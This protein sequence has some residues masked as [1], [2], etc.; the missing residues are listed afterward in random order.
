MVV[1]KS[2]AS[3]IPSSKSTE[4][5]YKVHDKSVQNSNK[6]NVKRE[7]VVKELDVKT[8]LNG[9]NNTGQPPPPLT[10]TPPQIVPQQ[11]PSTINH[12]NI[13][14]TY[15]QYV[16]DTKEVKKQDVFIKKEY[17]PAPS[18]MVK[19]EKTRD[20]VVRSLN[21]NSTTTTTSA[22][23]TTYTNGNASDSSTNSKHDSNNHHQHANGS[24]V[25]P[26]PS[27]SPAVRVKDESVKVKQEPKDEKSFKPTTSSSSSSTSKA[28]GKV[29]LVVSTTSLQESSKKDDRDRDRDRDKKR[30][31]NKDRSSSSNSRHKSSR[32]SSRSDC[33]RCYRRSKIKRANIG[34][35]CRR[36]KPPSALSF[37]IPPQLSTPSRIPLANRDFNC[38]RVG[39]EG[40]KYGRFFRIEV[41]P[42]GGASF[43]HL[44]QDEINCLSPVEMDELVQEFFKVCF[45]EDE[46]GFAHHVMGIVH[47]AA[48]YIPDLL[49]HM[50]ENYSQLTVKAGVLGRNNDI[51]TCTMQQ[52]YEQVAKHYAEGT[53]RY[54][55]LHQ[56]S[57]VG[58][59]H[60]EVGGYFPDLL[61]RIE[62]NPFLN[63]VRI[64]S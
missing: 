63:Q 9:D 21:F 57:L 39:L 18:K 23:S 58:K 28:N 44:Y 29:S 1:T 27:P 7:P 36:D 26:S 32:H 54:G 40:L 47:D 43:V 56:I 12:P 41:H 30:D 16:P 3:Q 25:V 13:Y 51:E 4:K 64:L 35:Q 61:A 2:D 53:I 38:T 49:E 15:G 46:D 50:A 52:Y 62:S 55:P 42:N 37:N 5:Q 24:R 59:V 20:D 60:E 48:A 11:H 19:I 6:E 14:L 10:P 8:E 33:S 34:I 31:Q 45:S 22:S 17:L